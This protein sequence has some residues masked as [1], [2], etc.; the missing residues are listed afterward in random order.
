MVGS[1][2]EKDFTTRAA[3]KLDGEF[4]HHIISRDKIQPDASTRSLTISPET[5]LPLRPKI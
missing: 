3:R 5:T 2:P 4:E 1:Y